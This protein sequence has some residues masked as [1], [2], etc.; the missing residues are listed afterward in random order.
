[1]SKSQPAYD[2]SQYVFLP[3]YIQ[4]LHFSQSQK[5]AADLGSCLRVYFRK[6]GQRVTN[7]WCQPT[8][9]YTDIEV[10]KMRDVRLHVQLG[11]PVKVES[12][13]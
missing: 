13:L 6:T 8:C 9:S 2:V 3:I 7:A 10:D 1:M 11:K 5:W 4:K 12:K